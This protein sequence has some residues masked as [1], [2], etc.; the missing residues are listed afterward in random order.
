MKQHRPWLDNRKYSK[1]NPDHFTLN[2]LHL[3]KTITIINGL[4]LGIAVIAKTKFSIILVGYSGYSGLLHFRLNLVGKT[5]QNNPF[6][7]QP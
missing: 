6:L 4:K 3:T 5:A 2:V 7:K 1:S